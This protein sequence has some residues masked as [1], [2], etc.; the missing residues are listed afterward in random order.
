MFGYAQN[1]MAEIACNISKNV[2]IYL[3]VPQKEN[4]NWCT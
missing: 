2:Q 4:L 1:L 3:I